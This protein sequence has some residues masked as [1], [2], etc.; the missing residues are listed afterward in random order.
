MNSLDQ[1]RASYCRQPIPSYSEQIELGRLVQAWQ[2]WPGPGACPRVIER[3]G[4]RARDRLVAGNLRL[5]ITESSRWRRACQSDEEMMELMQL[6]AIGLVRAA[7]KYDPTTGYKFS[8]YAHWWIRQAMGRSAPNISSVIYV[9]PCA[10]DRFQKLSRL[11]ASY[12]ASHNGVRPPIEYLMQETG[13]SKAQIEDAVVIGRARLVSS[14]DATVQNSGDG[15][16]SALGELVASSQATPMDELTAA[17]HD[18]RRS[19]LVADLIAALPEA[20]QVIVKDQLAGV[21]VNQVALEAGRSRARIGQLRQ[22]AAARL[23]KS[24]EH[25]APQLQEL[26]AA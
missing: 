5:V 25:V 15:E 22:R 10:Q 26:I 17:D 6:G 23:R 11:I 4:L 14:L 18:E 24:A 12:E 7:E 9:P 21:T 16:A 3:R 20:D 8:T 13:L 1:M 2:Q 19:A